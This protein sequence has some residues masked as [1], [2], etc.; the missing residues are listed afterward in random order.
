MRPIVV[1]T[2]PGLV[3]TYKAEMAQCG[4]ETWTD[5]LQRFDDANIIQ[6]WSYGA[7]R[8]GVQSLSHVLLKQGVEV[9]AAAQAIIIRVPLIGGGMAYVKSGPLWQLRGRERNLEVF[10]QMLRVLRHIYVVRQGLLLRIFPNAID[11]GTGVMRS[12]LKD[13]G[14]ERDQSV[15]PRKTAIIDL[16]YSLEELRTSLKKSWRHNLARAERSGLKVIG[17]ISD[18]L[19]ETLIALYKQM[20]ARKGPVPIPDIDYFRD[21]HRDSPD[22]FKIWITICEHEGESVAGVAVS[23]IGAAAIH[24]LAATGDRGLDCRASYLLHW[25]MLEWLKARG[26]RWYDLNCINPETHPGTYQFKT[27][28]SGRLGKEVE[29][30]GQFQA[31]ENRMSLWSVKAG[32]QLRRTYDGIK[33]ALRRKGVHG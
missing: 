7:A 12:I 21:I 17:G 33:V 9:V 14:F 29:Y 27:G 23:L 6:T 24:W 26:C 13:E 10:R 16:S 31:C 8:W 2:S 28:L 22:A 30:L 5:I 3:S 15:G 19:L 11:D 32:E 25:Q 18:E 4:P 20:Q 1:A